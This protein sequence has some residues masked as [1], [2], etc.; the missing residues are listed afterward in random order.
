[1]EC[2][3]SARIEK[4]EVKNVEKRGGGGKKA[5]GEETAEKIIEYAEDNHR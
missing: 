1:M 3:D 2:K 5:Y 4:Q